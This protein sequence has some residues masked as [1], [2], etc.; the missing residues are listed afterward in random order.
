MPGDNG[1]LTSISGERKTN[2]VRKRFLLP[3]LGDVLS[4]PRFEVLGG[5]IQGLIEMAEIAGVGPAGLNI[6]DHTRAA[7]LVTADAFENAVGRMRHVAVVTITARR[8]RRVAGMRSELG[9][10]AEFVVTLETRSTCLTDASEHV[11]WSTI[12]TGVT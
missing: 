8:C 7:D 12:V 4:I 3:Y 2:G 11:I 9:R 6:V 5:P 10:L 1:S